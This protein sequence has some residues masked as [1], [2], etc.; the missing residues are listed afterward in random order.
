MGAGMWRRSREA[1]ERVILKASEERTVKRS[2]RALHGLDDRT[3][4]D[5]GIMRSEIESCSRR[6]RQ[7][8][9]YY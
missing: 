4:K 5:I 6:G 1:L 8:R 7:K 3:L 9:P 2:V